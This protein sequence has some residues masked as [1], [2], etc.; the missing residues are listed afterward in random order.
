MRFFQPNLLMFED[1]I[2]G[3]LTFSDCYNKNLYV[4]HVKVNFSL[5]CWWH[6]TS[7]SICVSDIVAQTIIRLDFTPPQNQ[8]DVIKWVFRNKRRRSN[9]KLERWT[10]ASELKQTNKQTKVS[11]CWLLLHPGVSLVSCSLWDETRWRVIWSILW[12]AGI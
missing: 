6:G 5:K 9:H 7:A 12:A 11:N 10:L 3:L 4:C 8:F 1:F 2:E